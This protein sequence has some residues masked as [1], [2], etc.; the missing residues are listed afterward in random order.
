MS[1]KQSVFD[2]IR[3]KLIVSCQ[4][5]EDE[6]LHGSETMCKMAIAAMRGGAG[7]IRCNS[8]QDITAI[9]AAVPLPLIGIYKREYASCPVFITPTMQ[10]LDA[11]ALAAPDIIA[12]DATNRERPDGLSLDRFFSLAREKYPQAV[13]MADCSTFEEASHAASIGFDCVGTT[14]CGYTAYTRGQ[15]LPNFKLIGR[16][17]GQPLP[18]FKL[19]G[20]LAQSLSIPVIAEGGIWTPLQLRHVMQLGVHAAVIGT[21]ITRPM[22]ITRRF[23]SAIGG[24]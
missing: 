21:A 16:L 8:P 2:S 4:A 5:L 6:P 12:L 7:G 18:N 9:R 19:I 11:V 10:E 20:R 24:R 22:E 13:F 15:P 17:R 1:A 3:G 23:V 14:L